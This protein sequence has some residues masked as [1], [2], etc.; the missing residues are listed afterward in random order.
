MPDLTTGLVLRKEKAP[1]IVRSGGRGGQPHEWE[2][3]IGPTIAGSPGEDFLI[4]I[5]PDTER[6]QGGWSE[7]D[8]LA[9]KR[10][11]SAR[12]ASIANRYWNHVPGEHVQ[13]SVRQREDGT[14]G[15]YATHH[16]PMTDEARAKIAN[17]RK[18]RGTTS[19]QDDP[20]AD[21][22]EVPAPSATPPPAASTPSSGSTAAERLKT[23]AKKQQ[24]RR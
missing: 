18:P 4:Y 13:T 11:A 21:E 6:P 15:V 24:G 9:A 14:F 1:P 16:G 10:Q 2:K 7:E 20:G 22:T 5:Y 12:S 19:A 17:R 8:L 3:V 23:A